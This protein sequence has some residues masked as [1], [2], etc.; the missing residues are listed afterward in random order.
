MMCDMYTYVCIYMYIYIYE[1]ICIYM[2]ICMY[3]ER[4]GLPP[5]VSTPQPSTI[6]A[7][8]QKLVDKQVNMSYI[9]EYTWRVLY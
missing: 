2:Y 1:C 4:Q 9:Y 6:A 8:K 7:V 3:T 5:P